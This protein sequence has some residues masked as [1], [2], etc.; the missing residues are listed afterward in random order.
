MPLTRRIGFA[1]AALSIVACSD[2]PSGPTPS[3][4]PDVTALLAEMSSS[5]IGMAE[6]LAGSPSVGVM[7]SSSSDPSTCT[8]NEATGFFV[9]PTVTTGSLTVSRMYRFVDAAGHSQPKADA[10]TSAFETKMS[11]SGKITMTTTEPRTSTS[12]YT[13]NSNSDQTLSGLR[14]ENHTLNGLTTTAIEG[15]L[16]LG[17][18][19]LPLDEHLKETTSNLVLPSARKGQKWPLSGTIT[20][21]ETSNDFDQPPSGSTYQTS[22]TF[23][24]TSVVTL[25]FTSPFGTSSCKVDLAAPP[26]TGFVGCLP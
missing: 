10:Q 2:S 1:V 25:T 19:T 20:I 4:V 6:A 7:L 9:C 5:S 21:E 17:D 23:N 24:G 26:G 13:I 3:T 12:S 18:E 16:Q 22:I 15:A 8:Y 14:A 11:V